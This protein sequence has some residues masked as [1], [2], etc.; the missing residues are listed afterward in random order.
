MLND[1]LSHYEVH[2]DIW[3]FQMQ[4]L[5]L[6]KEAGA[7]DVRRR[8]MRKKKGEGGRLDIIS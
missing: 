3:T 1:S 4:A 8:E 7:I 5:R 2:V 6:Q